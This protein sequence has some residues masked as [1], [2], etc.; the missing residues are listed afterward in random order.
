MGWFNGLVPDGIVFRDFAG[1]TVVHTV[2]GM[3]RPRRRHRPRPPP[4]PQVQAVTAAAPRLRTTSTSPPSAPSS[5]GSA[6]TASTPARPCRPW[7]SRASAGWPPTPRSPPAPAAWSP[8]SSS[9]PAPRSGTWACRSTASSAASS[10]SPPLLL[11]VTR[12]APSSSAP[13]PA[14]SSRSAIDLLEHLRIDDPIG[15]VPVHGVCGIWGTLA[16]ASSPPASSASRPPTGADNTVAD[17]GPLLRRRHRPAA[18]PRSSAAS[19]ASSWSASS[20]L[21]ADV[22]P[23][24]ASPAAWN[25]RL[26]RGRRARGH[27]HR[28]A[29][30]ARLPHGVRRRASATP[31]TPAAPAPSR[32][33]SSRPDAVSAERR[34]GRRLGAQVPCPPS[35]TRGSA[36]V[37]AEILRWPAD[38]DRR[39]ELRRHGHPCLLVLDPGACPPTGR[40]P[41]GLGSGPR[42]TS[43][44]SSPGSTVSP[45]AR[46][47]GTSGRATWS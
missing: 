18:S 22:R 32:A 33:P 6:G 24:A 12:S 8:C 27:R 5:C 10:P 4:R 13:S 3:H 9:T 34:D 21:V 41:G 14:S 31:R 16:S 20:A 36:A 29:R 43:V 39:E 30:P 25:L 42:P 7:T 40:R 47:R 17:R 11:G 28:R 45:C 38:A 1:S 23:S 46:A 26:D 19:A 37:A 44:T 2:G 15:A 35:R